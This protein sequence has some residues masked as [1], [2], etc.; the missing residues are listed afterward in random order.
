MRPQLAVILLFIGAPGFAAPL[1]L[2]GLCM[3]LRSGATLNTEAKRI[4]SGK[5]LDQELDA[6]LK[7]ADRVRDAACI[8]AETKRSVHLGALLQVRNEHLVPEVFSAL[9]RIH[10]PKNEEQIR[11]AMKSWIQSPNR[12]D[13][14]LKTLGAL[15]VLGAL[16]WRPNIRELSGLLESTIP[17]VR[18]GSHDFLFQRFDQLSV[19]ERQELM[20][21]A[22]KRDPLQVRVSAIR[23]FRALKD[24]EKKALQID[25]KDCKKDPEPEVR[26]ECP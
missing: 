21:A 4:L 11:T 19:Q 26:E 9:T 7:D 6:A 15:Q 20:K 8:I 17:E 16:Q 22:L 3:G 24:Q 14:I 18:M 25:L 1:D 12:E 5:P 10:S 23:T 13:H 2:Y